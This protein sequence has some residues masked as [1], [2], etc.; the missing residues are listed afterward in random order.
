MLKNYAV[1]F[2]NQRTGKV[3]MD[4]FTSPSEGAAR[5]D[6]G[7]CYRH[8]VYAILATVEVP[9]INKGKGDVAD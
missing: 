4:I 5:S 3:G 1:V 8:E 2:Q 6:F 9:E 7:A